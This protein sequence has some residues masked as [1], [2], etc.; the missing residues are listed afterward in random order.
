MDSGS[1]VEGKVQTPS[2]VLC[3]CPRLKACIVFVKPTVTFTATFLKL[4][5]HTSLLS[6]TLGSFQTDSSLKV[7]KFT[8]QV[9]IMKQ[10]LQYQR[11]PLVVSVEHCRNMEVLPPGDLPGHYS[12]SEP[13]CWS[14]AGL[15]G[16]PHSGSEERKDDSRLT[17][18]SSSIPP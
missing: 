12:C 3:A 17:G 6:Y 9:G 15:E 16:V 2:P 10:R 14:A 11:G 7:I 5:H 8:P 18:P 4:R 1:W 13:L